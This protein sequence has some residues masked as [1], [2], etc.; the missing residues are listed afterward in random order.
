MKILFN[1]IVENYS[2]L[3][4]TNQSVNYPVTNLT[5]FF[6]RR[7]FQS[8]SSSSLITIDFDENQCVDCIFFGFFSGTFFDVAF[9]DS[10]GSILLSLNLVVSPSTQ[11]V[12]ESF[13]KLTNVRSIEIAMEGFLGGIGAGCCYEMP[14]FLSVYT[15]GNIDNSIDSESAGGQ[16][17]QNYI[18]PLRRYEFSFAGLSD[19]LIDEI[20]DNYT[21]VGKG[22]PLYVDIFEGAKIKAPPIY[23][24]ITTALDYTIGRISNSFQLI[25]KEAR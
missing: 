13:T 3:I 19:T 1:N 16:S 8:D 9:K 14:N 24:K 20:D 22:K 23:C 12:S 7:R 15:K 18:K 10:T 25:I 11:V 21:S 2:S 6:L 5:H 17:S 4:A